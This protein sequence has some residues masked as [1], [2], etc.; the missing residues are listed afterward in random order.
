MHPIVSV[1]GECIFG[2]GDLGN[3][4]FFVI[5]G[6]LEVI[7]NDEVISILTDGDFFGEIALFA[8]RKKKLQL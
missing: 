3:E 5:R 8:E 1:P 4:M 2:E 7:L 6:K